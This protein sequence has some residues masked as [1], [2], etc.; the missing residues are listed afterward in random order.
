MSSLDVVFCIICGSLSA[1]LYSQDTVFWVSS[2]KHTTSKSRHACVL[3]A[4]SICLYIVSCN[5]MCFHPSE[6]FTSL[7]CDCKVLSSPC[8]GIVDL[9]L[10]GGRSSFSVMHSVSS[11]C[12]TSTPCYRCLCGMLLLLA[13]ILPRRAQPMAVWFFKST[14]TSYV[15]FS[16]SR[17]GPL[18]LGLGSLDL[19][20]AL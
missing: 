18:G 4:L 9:T 19:V 5:V 12:E 20:R 6:D 10:L 16:S 3:G 11:L 8:D 15:V 1:S 17:D 2:C 14:T 13:C 7:S